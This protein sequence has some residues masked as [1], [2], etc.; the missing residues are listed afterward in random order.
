MS[1]K[2]EYIPEGTHI[3]GVWLNFLMQFR[4]N[5]TV[6]D[7]YNMAGCVLLLIPS[8]VIPWDFVSRGIIYPFII[9]PVK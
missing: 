6:R 5:P 7:M 3:F 8:L 9:S 4:Y 1:I 2:L